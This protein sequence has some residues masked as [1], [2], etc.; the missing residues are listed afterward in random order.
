MS[1]FNESTIFRKIL[2]PSSLRSNDKILNDSLKAADD[3]ITSKAYVTEKH[4][5][6]YCISDLHADAEKNQ[7]WVQQNLIRKNDDENNFTI[8]IIPGDI[9]SEMDKIVR[10]FSHV[11]DQY[12]AICYL[13]GNHEL[14]KRGSL[15]SPLKEC[16]NSIEKFHEILECANS[17][18][19]NIGPIRVTSTLSTLS[20]SSLCIFPLYS[21]YHSSWDTEPDIN[22]PL[23][24]KGECD[25]PFVSRWADFQLC[26]W[27]TNMIKHSEFATINPNNDNNNTV[28]AEA[29][30]QLNEKFLIP[31]GDEFVEETMIAHVGNTSIEYAAG[32][33]ISNDIK[34]KAHE[35]P[36]VQKND[37]V[38][39]FSHFVPRQ[40]CC[41]EKRFLLEPLLSKV[42][43]S[44]PLEYQ[45]R[46]LRP[47]LHLFGHTHIPID[48]DLDGISYLQWPLGYTR[49]SELQCE[50]IVAL[51]PILVYDSSAT[52]MV[53]RSS[54]KSTWS[55]YYK[56]TNRQPHITDDLSPW[57][58]EKLK[59]NL[60]V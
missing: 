17:F 23:Y 33:Q 7:A 6:V 8:L 19:I 50:Q 42:I 53:E 2:I 54:Q 36:L 9:G 47:H 37:T 24:L 18:N 52:G 16:D 43:G 28:L 45:I 58:A 13:P 46:R 1:G 51:G 59:K 15:K 20:T 10:V 26:S 32:A 48:L 38:I 25:M 44:N 39:S 4:I 57:L 31:L 27:P 12:D 49:E 56:E 3:I 5:K 35:S 60:K 34:V 30:A 21:W 14:W 22:H 55:K 11:V 29:F 41:P 40:E